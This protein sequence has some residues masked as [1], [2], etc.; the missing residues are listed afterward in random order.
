MRKR[1][2]HRKNDITGKEEKYCSKCKQWVEL[3]FYNIKK[4]SWDGLETCCMICKRSLSKNYRKQKPDY[5]REY[6]KKN[7][8]KLREYKKQYYQKLK[9]K[10]LK[11]D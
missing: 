7:K 3:S 10:I 1:I 2:A 11:E 9:D 5:D 6:Q 4:A 8:Q